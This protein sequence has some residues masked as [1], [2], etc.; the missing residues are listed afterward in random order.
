MKRTPKLYQI[1][2][3]GAL[4]KTILYY[5]IGFAILVLCIFYVFSFMIYENRIFLFINQAITI[6]LIN[7]IVGF[8][9][10]PTLK[11]YPLSGKFLYAYGLRSR[12]INSGNF[13]S[14]S[15][16]HG[17]IIQTKNDKRINIR[18]DEFPKID[19]QKLKDNFQAIF[20]ENK[21]IKDVFL[22]NPVEGF[23]VANKT[24]LET[25]NPWPQVLFIFSCVAMVAYLFYLM[26][27]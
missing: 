16:G 25:P 8:N 2:G 20:I 17:I 5:K 22:S 12:V 14:L 4:A 18:L 11:I 1:T 13:K 10:N 3:K 23:H 21:P 19:I 9:S 15:V 7:L 6:A 26:L 24:I 27:N